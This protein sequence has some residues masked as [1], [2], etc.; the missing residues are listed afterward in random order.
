M[1]QGA[2]RR[3]QAGDGE[4]LG[5]L[6]AGDAAALGSLYDRYSSVVF[7]LCVRILGSRADAEEVLAD[8]FWE[9]WSRPGRYD[10]GRGNLLAYL[11]TLA[12]SRA[13][14]RLRSRRS[15]AMREATAADPPAE[16]G[17]PLDEAVFGER[18]RLVQRAL[19]EL[20]PDQRQAI[21]LSFY[22]GLSHAE[23]SDEL[24]EPLGTI[25]SRIRSGLVRLRDSLRTL[26]EGPSPS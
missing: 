4:L 16:A 22:S 26:H 6:A 21:E 25:K 3:G 15:R 2:P 10:P 17:S 20:T 14:D 11:G 13:V 9:L 23:I 8:V 7:A 24:R 19:G 12:R 18:R 5:A 1:G